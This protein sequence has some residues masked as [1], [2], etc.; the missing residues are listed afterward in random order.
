M[1]YAERSILVSDGEVGEEKDGRYF[2]SG[3]W[4]SW[5]CMAPLVKKPTFC[6][7][8]ESRILFAPLSALPILASRPSAPVTVH[9]DF[10]G[11]PPFEF[12]DSTDLWASGPAPGNSD[13]IPAFTIDA[14]ANDFTQGELD[15]IVTVWQHVSEKFSPFDINVTTVPPPN[16]NDG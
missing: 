9:L 15:S 14:N 10:D 2:I 11:T 4:R 16:Y 1:S 6:E 7:P 8:L 12:N 13:P 5:S 3:K